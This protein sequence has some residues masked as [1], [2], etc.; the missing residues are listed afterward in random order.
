MTN[1]TDPSFLERARGWITRHVELVGEIEQ[2]HNFPWSTVLRVPTAD[3]AVY[4]KAV[5]DQSGFEP[6]LTR[7]LGEIAP[8][9]VVETIAIESDE[10]WMLMG[11]AG[12][13]LREH[14]STSSDLGHWDHVLPL[15]AQVQMETMQRTDEL[16]HMG[17]PDERLERLPDN[18]EEFLGDPGFLMLGREDGLSADEL[19]RMR[20]E[21][22]AL[23]E[24]CV[25]LASAGVPAALQHDDLNDGN[26]FVDQ[27]RYRV[28]DWGDSCVSH[29]FHTLTVLLRSTA[30]RLKLDAGAAEL[31]RMRDVYLEPFEVF[32]PRDQLRSAAAI[33]NRT[34]TLARAHAWYRYARAKEPGPARDDDIEAI[35]YGVKMYLQND[36]IGAWKP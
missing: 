6:R 19:A 24:M 1:W 28:V 34:G 7:L 13:R 12:T 8:M 27:G 22:P 32:A 26:V 36:P 16:L 9:V 15:Y 18:I 25:E 21:L 20:S 14:V 23:T 33:A 11:D 35:P 5:S 4:F 29:P 17:V 30:Y 10:G 2:I 3:G 31:E